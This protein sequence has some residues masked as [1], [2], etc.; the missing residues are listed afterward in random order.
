MKTTQTTVRQT[1]GRI[2]GLICFLA[3][4]LFAAAL[5][6]YP[7]FQGF[8]LSF[9]EYTPLYGM[10]NSPWVGTQ[11]YDQLLNGPYFYS[12]LKNSF[13]LGFLANLI[14]IA[15]GF[16]LGW[17]LAKF[18]GGRLAGLFLGIWLLPVF[19]PA[20]LYTAAAVWM[21]GA[22]LLGNPSSAV[23]VY[24]GAAGIRTL[25]FSVFLCGICGYL[26][27]RSG[28]SSTKGSLLG[29][30][31]LLMISAINL[32]TPSLEILHG[33]QNPLNYEAT[34]TLDTYAYR[35][36]L[37]N[38]SFSPS[39]AAWCVKLLLELPFFL[40]AVILFLCV[41]KSVPFRR[42]AGSIQE[43]TSLPGV[44][45]LI[46]VGIFSIFAMALFISLLPG[47]SPDFGIYAANSTLISLFTAVLFFGF[48]LLFGY[49]SAS[50]P[51]AGIALGGLLL[52]VSCN[53]VGEYL[54]YRQAYAINTPWPVILNG[55][56]LPT[57][58]IPFLVISVLIFQN[59]PCG[60]F[61]DWIHRM[62]PF[63][64]LFTGLSMANAWGSSEASVIYISDNAKYGLSIA[65]R[66]A[67]LSGNT[68]I[69]A[70]IGIPDD[71]G[72]TGVCAV[73]CIVPFCIGVLSVILFTITDLRSSDRTAG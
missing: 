42:E 61:G 13:V 25:C 34:D 9:Q 47:E 24:M 60:G 48:L 50:R 33:I 38:A 69:V 32:L 3:V 58:L 65:L 23:L 6:F 35:T 31:V 67:L 39:A 52:W 72:F 41:L 19:L 59:R 16:L 44:F 21:G 11:N 71:I 64:L 53:T 27:K 18:S 22:E 49:G 2:G 14:P 70:P 29:G 8:L 1:T 36:G 56:F 17:P 55:V 40:I 51:A 26:C 28:A 37:M 5:K 73:F 63:L 15:V 30:G 12:I 20:Q 7:A 4:V 45:S 62:L 43:S 66:N 68:G 57:L 10:T 46:A 54:F